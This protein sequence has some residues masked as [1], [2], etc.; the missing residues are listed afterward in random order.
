MK[1]K[2]VLEKFTEE[3]DPIHDMGIGTGVFKTLSPGAVFKAKRLGIAVT[4][5]KSGHFTSFR[6]GI[7]IRPDQYCIIVSIKNYGPKYKDIYFTRC[8]INEIQYT[9][10]VIKN[11]G[12][13]IQRR[14]IVSKKM[15]DNR[16]EII[17]KGF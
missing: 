12:W 16:F 1:A 8:H 2:F 3:G 4:R 13:V 11:N 9:K 5:N 15:F 7:N 6:T 14:M 17:E 10:K